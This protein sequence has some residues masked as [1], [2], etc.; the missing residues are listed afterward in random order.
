MT[1]TRTTDNVAISCPATAAILTTFSGLTG[2]ALYAVN[3]LISSNKEWQ[4]AYTRFSP[5]IFMACGGI[6]A[7]CLGT[8]CGTALSIMTVGPAAISM[9]AG[10]SYIP[11]MPIWTPPLISTSTISIV[12][13]GTYAAYRGASSGC[14]SFWK[15]APDEIACDTA[16]EQQPLKGPQNV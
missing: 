7:G 10:F 12:A 13:L 16:A 5:A 6:F 14:F 2:N 4:S 1:T 3:S 8:S 11:G 9:S 15:K